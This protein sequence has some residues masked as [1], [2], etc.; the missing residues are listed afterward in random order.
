MS[1]GTVVTGSSG[2]RAPPSP[3]GASTPA[4]ALSLAAAASLAV[5]PAS[6]C[7]RPVSGCRA[8][9]GVGGGLGASDA[10]AASQDVHNAAIKV[11][12]LVER[13]CG[14]MPPPS[15][16][17]RG[18]GAKTARFERP[19]S[20][21]LPLPQT[22]EGERSGAGPRS[23]CPY[24]RRAPRA[25]DRPL[26]GEGVGAAAAGD[27]AGG[28]GEAGGGDS[29]GGGL[30]VDVP[31]EVDQQ[32]V[33]GVGEVVAGAAVGD[34]GVGVVEAV[35]VAQRRSPGRRRGRGPPSRRRPGPGRGRRS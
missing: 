9:G 7:G 12:R 5:V 3:P 14:P 28:A 4:G 22:G 2:A 23:G 6:A 1:S 11:T 13:G 26:P 19:E 17:P 10:Q 25:T 16:T 31:G 29:P 30:A 15:H 18:A 20:S 32:A 35:V 33:A 24:S 34:P 27:G 8:S 21:P